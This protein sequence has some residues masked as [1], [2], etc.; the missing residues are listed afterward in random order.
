MTTPWLGWVV[1]VAAIRRCPVPI[2]SRLRSN[3]PS[4]LVGK[5]RPAARR[6]RFTDL[7]CRDAG[8]SPGG[9]G[10]QHGGVH[11]VDRSGHGGQLRDEPGAAGDRIITR[12]IEQLDLSSWVTV[13]T[14]AADPAMM[15]TNQLDQARPVRGTTRAARRPARS[16][17]FDPLRTDPAERKLLA[18]GA[19]DL[20][21]RGRDA[22]GCECHGAPDPA[23]R[24]RGAGCFPRPS[25]RPR[26]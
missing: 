9:C 26:F 15:I 10:D 3:R 19:G 13:S 2:L 22:P 14:M 16:P 23:A 18:G 5:D 7:P 4:F 20:R 24:D 1:T 21:R 17:H 8:G 11:R 6:Y 25:A 12:E